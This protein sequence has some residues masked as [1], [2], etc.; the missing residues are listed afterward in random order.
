[1]QSLVQYPLYLETLF[2]ATLM[3]DLYCKLKNNTLQL[4]TKNKDVHLEVKEC[5]W[6]DFKNW[7]EETSL[8]EKNLFNFLNKKQPPRHLRNFEQNH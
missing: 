1:M 8:E 4:Q 6:K 7:I 5:S 2:N 3:Q